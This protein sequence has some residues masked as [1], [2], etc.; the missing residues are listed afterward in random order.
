MWG[1]AGTRLQ[2]SKVNPR[3]LRSPARRRQNGVTTKGHSRDI[4][5]AHNRDLRLML[6]TDSK[7]TYPCLQIPNA[8]NHSLKW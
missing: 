6:G 7:S 4:E 3:E 8:N 1:D 2:G 5:K